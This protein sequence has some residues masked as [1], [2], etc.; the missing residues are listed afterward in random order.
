MKNLF[1]T[2]F[3]LLFIFCDLAFADDYRPIGT[4]PSSTSK[5][6]NPDIFLKS[7]EANF[8]LKDHYDCIRDR[9]IF[10]ELCLGMPI[11]GVYAVLGLPDDSRKRMI[12]GT[13]H[14]MLI[15]K[16]HS[17]SPVY[18]FLEDYRLTGWKK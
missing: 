5:V 14:H 11:T 13:N 15:Y 3:L 12:E 8:L 9:T 17:S 4:R 2:L 18:V 16:M 1:C 10:D 6:G 7:D